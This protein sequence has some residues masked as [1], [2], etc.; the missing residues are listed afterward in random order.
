MEQYAITKRFEQNCETQWEEDHRHLIDEDDE[1]NLGG[2]GG[3]D[4]GGGGGGG[5]DDDD[6]MMTVYYDPADMHHLM[7]DMLIE[8]QFEHQKLL[9]GIDN[10][11]N[12]L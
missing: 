8:R 10:N 2:D 11:K 4:D 1:E 3:G 9:N 5:D 6:E 7:S 12:I